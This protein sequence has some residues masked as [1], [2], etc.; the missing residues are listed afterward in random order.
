MVREM[1]DLMYKAEGVGLAANQV[2]LPYQLLVMNSTADPNQPEEEFVLINPV[3]T[4]RTGAQTEIE[5]GCL[6]FPDLHLHITRPESVE[7]Q[8]INLKGELCRYK[9][10]GLKARIVQHETDHLKGLCFYQ[11]APIS[12]EFR[13]KEVLASLEQSYT[14]DLEN[15]FVPNEAQL[16]ER[17]DQWLKERA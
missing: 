3:I 6:S 10:K 7:F 12:E 9:W 8:A 15:G 13:A 14:I 2:E 16:K 4:K 1:F 5:E 11:R 17:I